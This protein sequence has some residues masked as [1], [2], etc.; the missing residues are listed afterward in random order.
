ME[1]QGLQEPSDRHIPHPTPAESALNPTRTI[2]YEY[3]HFLKRDLSEYDNPENVDFTCTRESFYY[4]LLSFSSSE[5]RKQRA[6]QRFNMCAIQQG[7]HA[8][9]VDAAI[10]AYSKLIVNLMNTD[11]L[12]S[13][14]EAFGVV[15]FLKL[16]YADEMSDVQSKSRYDQTKDHILL[17]F[18]KDMLLYPANSALVYS[19]QIYHDMVILLID[20]FGDEE[21]F[22]R[23]SEI[24][25]HLIFFYL[26]NRLPD[27][28]E[29]YWGVSSLTKAHLFAYI[30]NTPAARQMTRS[31]P[32]MFEEIMSQVSNLG[33]P[34]NTLLGS[35]LYPE[36]SRYVF[37]GLQSN[38]L[39]QGGKKRTLRNKKK[40]INKN[41][42][43]NK[44]NKKTRRS[45]FSKVK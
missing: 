11:T 13:M 43:N 12:E 6:I 26:F 34:L 21:R 38:T 18:G 40:R 30:L 10:H 1:A 36:A 32:P 42:K 16:D 15:E 25:K 14:R 17:L 24:V 3:Q 9:P 20:I 29:K 31:S 2:H 37:E 22:I 35:G 7:P 39:G 5:S 28:V 44:N 19:P 45:R 33:S 41:N 27:M 23:S 8:D 4:A